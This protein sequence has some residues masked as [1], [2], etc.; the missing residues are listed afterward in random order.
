MEA[1]EKEL[2]DAPPVAVKTKEGDGDEGEDG[3]DMEEKDLGEDVFAMPSAPLDVGDEQETW[4]GTDRDYTYS[5][6][7]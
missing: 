5:E 4:H 2:G 7:H 3:I 1:F 6:V